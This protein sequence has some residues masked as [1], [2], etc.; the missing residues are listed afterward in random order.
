[1]NKSI[2]ICVLA[3][4]C[5]A[6]CAVGGDRLS[7]QVFPHSVIGSN[8]EHDT[9]EKLLRNKLELLAQ[10]TVSAHPDLAQLRLVRVDS[11][12]APLPASSEAL[13]AYWSNSPD[14]LEVLSGAIFS[15]PSVI[16]SNVY[17]GDLQGSLD[18]KTISVRVA[19]TPEEFF[20]YRDVHGALMLYALAM[21]AKRQKPQR[22]VI[23]QYLAEA[24]SLLRTVEQR[25]ISGL[26]TA[27]KTLSEAISKELDKLKK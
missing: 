13:E 24:E 3:V 5:F 9:V 2:P 20:S 12:K 16:A 17:L 21:D 25:P 1:M 22:G 7:I 14:A 15:N 10:Q 8:I 23:S 6:A 19:L 26:D 11:I 18:A 27:V 4:S